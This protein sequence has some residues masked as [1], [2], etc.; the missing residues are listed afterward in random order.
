M[1]NTNY[2]RVLIAPFSGSE[3]G[4]ARN[5]SGRKVFG[6]RQRVF[7]AKSFW[8]VRP[9]SAALRAARL[10]SKFECDEGGEMRLSNAGGVSFF[11]FG[12]R[13]R[14]SRGSVRKC[15]T[16]H[17]WGQLV[18]GSILS[19]RPVL[20]QVTG[21][22]GRP[23]VREN[24][25]PGGYVAQRSS[26][27]PPCQGWSGWVC[28]VR[29]GV[30][31]AQHLTRGLV[32]RRGSAIR[33]RACITPFGL[34]FTILA[35]LRWVYPRRLSLTF[36]SSRWGAVGP[37]RVVAAHR[38]AV[39]SMRSVCHQAHVLDTLVHTLGELLPADSASTRYTVA[40]LTSSV[41]AMVPAYWPRA[42]I[43]CARAALEAS[44]ALGRPID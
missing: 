5:W 35:I 39:L 26:D 42:C 29:R 33:R 13:A 34:M 31:P 30:S 9:L 22:F 8:A 10:R 40:R 15:V 17:F 11:F 25:C 24:R 27:R 12:C 21:R 6:E 7:L 2:A 14:R 44:S 4:A 36:S 3:C 16:A 1:H 19:A 41:V 20:A 37:G 32:Q 38:L 28:R 18:A 43:G 23:Q